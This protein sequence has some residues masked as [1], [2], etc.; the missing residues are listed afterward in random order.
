MYRMTTHK[1]QRNVGQAVLG[2]ASTYLE[3]EKYICT[4]LLHTMKSTKVQTLGGNI[5]TFGLE[6]SLHAY[7]LGMP[8]IEPRSRTI[9]IVL[10][11]HVYM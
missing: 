4:L 2:M 9:C 11:M 7:V 6:T 5:G 10:S 3:I 8:S 1:Q